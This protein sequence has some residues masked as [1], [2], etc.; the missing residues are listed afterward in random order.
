ML[1]MRSFKGLFTFISQYWAGQMFQSPAI[2]EHVQQSDQEVLLFRL[3]RELYAIPSSSVREVARFRP[4]T[5]VPGAPAVLPGI[6]SQRGMILP[7]VEPRPLLGLDQADFTR[8]A[9]LV[10]VIHNDIAMALLV[11]AVLDL[12]ALPAAAIEP[13][14]AALDPARARFLRGVARHDEQP[15]GLLDLN[16][17]IAGLREK[18]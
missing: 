6:I 2:A 4:W 18:S 10:V 15:L 9:R 17:L 13:V 14:P 5:P 11:E 12:V 7:I 3:E 1:R 16:E 8:A